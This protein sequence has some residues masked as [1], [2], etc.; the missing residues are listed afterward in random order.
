M[1]EGF[2]VSKVEAAAAAAAAALQALGL[3]LFFVF[4]FFGC[5]FLL[6]VVFAPKLLQALN[7]G[8]LNFRNCGG[9]G[10]SLVEAGGVLARDEARRGKGTEARRTFLLLFF[11]FFFFPRAW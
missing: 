11:F 7:C 4:L 8:P 5:P 9:K 3:V 1:S 6:P 2:E 10:R